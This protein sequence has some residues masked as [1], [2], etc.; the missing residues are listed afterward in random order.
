MGLKTWKHSPEG[1]ILKSDTTIAKNYLD[2]KEIKKLERL[3]SSYFDYLEH[4]VENHTTFKMEDLA[5][6]INKFLDFNEYKIL[7]DAGKI[8]KSQSEQKAFKEYEKYNKIQG[9][10]MESDFD[11]QIKSFLKKGKKL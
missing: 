9:K 10:K 7:G 1:R 2:E 3:I 8:S 6:S 4:L 5:E 11:K